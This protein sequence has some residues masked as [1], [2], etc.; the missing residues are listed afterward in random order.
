MVITQSGQAYYVNEQ[1]IP[2]AQGMAPV[3]LL[4]ENLMSKA[5]MSSTSVPSSTVVA[6]TTPTAVTSAI[7]GEC[8][9][10]L[11]LEQSIVSTFIYIFRNLD[12]NF[13]CLL[14]VV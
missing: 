13:F 5:A 14:F 12:Y 3:Q 11:K 2:V 1:G 7:Q 10:R 4:S 8:Y 9:L 6:S